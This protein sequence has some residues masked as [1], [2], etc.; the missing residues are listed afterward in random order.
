MIR[1]RSARAAIAA[2]L[3][4]SALGI[5][6]T[7]G[8]AEVPPA[9]QQGR[10][11][12]IL[13][14]SSQVEVDRKAARIFAS[15]PVQD[16]IAEL[17]ALYLADDLVKLPGARETAR[18]AAEANAMA[19]SFAAVAKD[20]GRPAVLWGTTGAHSWGDIHVPLS[21]TMIDNPDNIYRSIPVDGGA[22]YVIT[23]RIVFP[24][25]AQQTFTL[26]NQTA[27]T[28]KNEKVRSNLAENGS[29]SLQSLAIDRDGSFTITVDASPANG[30]KNHL[31][32]DP[33]ARNASILVR[34][35]LL[36][37]GR[38]NPVQLTV[39]RVAGP[40]IA[41]MASDAELAAKAARLTGSSAAYY[42]TWV[43]NGTYSG[44]P[45]GFTHNFTRVSGWGGIKQGHY[46][47]EPG[48]ALVVTVHRREAAYLGF[49]LADTWGQGQ[50]SE[51]IARTGSLNASQARANRDG[52]YT[53]VI[54]PDDPGVH[55]WLDTAGLR[56]G[57][58]GVRWQQMPPGVTLDDA[59]RDIR[60]VKVAA[61]KETLPPETVWATPEE[62]KAQIA[63]RQADYARRLQ[64]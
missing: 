1:N 4:A 53:F 58:Y 7:A 43:K 31:Q 51:F 57:I 44:P 61:L 39:S 59:V 16:A 42:R 37:W 18:R 32:T 41:P 14:T 50:A 33:E 20:T 38:E 64:Y 62:R 9:W 6:S 8:A 29:L 24:A 55:N 49:Q 22:S 36:D 46:L 13:G 21:G 54:S 26:Y 30:R 27:G 5:A 48:E 60:V 2:A 10:E 35:T 25:P 56:A 19:Q 40:P 28:Q 12:S 3:M 17:T 45:N 11:G 34:D 52:T 15:K 63:Q 23:G 47:L